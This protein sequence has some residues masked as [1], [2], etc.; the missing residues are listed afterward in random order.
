[1]M[2]KSCFDQIRDYSTHKVI[3]KYFHNK[4]YLSVTLLVVFITR[5]LSEIQH[6][7]LT[8]ISNNT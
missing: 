1:M 8:I 2:I 6:C 7:V 5:A 4:H 3:A